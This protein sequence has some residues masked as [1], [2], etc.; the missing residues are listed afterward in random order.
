MAAAHG[1]WKV[2]HVQVS[3]ALVLGEGF[4]RCL[5]KI[6]KSQWNIQMFLAKFHQHGGFSSQL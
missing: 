3:S 6:N 2:L 5:Q 1:K 4:F